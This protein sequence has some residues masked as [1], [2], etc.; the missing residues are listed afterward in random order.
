MYMNEESGKREQEAV[1]LRCLRDHYGIEGSLS[2]LGGENINYL[3]RA[4]ERK[5]SE[6]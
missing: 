3:V 2:R 1:A 4:N 5:R 6:R